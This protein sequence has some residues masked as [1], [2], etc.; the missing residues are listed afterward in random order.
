[1]PGKKYDPVSAAFKMRGWSP[2]TKSSP[3]KHG[4]GSGTPPATAT[5]SFKPPSRIEMKAYKMP[6]MLD[7]SMG[8]T[9]ISEERRIEIEQF[10]ANQ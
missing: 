5:S 7:T 9:N 3:T 8:E 6:H 4:D 10:L 2:F 1:M